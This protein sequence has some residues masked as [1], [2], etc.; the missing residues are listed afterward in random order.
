[1][2]TTKSQTITLHGIDESNGWVH[3]NPNHTTYCIFEYPDRL[4]DLLKKNRWN[5]LTS[6]ERQMMIH[7]EYLLAQHKKSSKSTKAI[8]YLKV[9]LFVLIH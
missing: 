9:K 2:L 4:R 1:M 3:F 5:G 8:D 7:S 6:T